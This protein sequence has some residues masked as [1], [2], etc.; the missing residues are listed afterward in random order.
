MLTQG[1]VRDLLVDKYRAL[2]EHRCDISNDALSLQCVCSLRPERAHGDTAVVCGQRHR[3]SCNHCELNTH[4]SCLFN[5]VF[6]LDKTTPSS[7]LLHAT[8]QTTNNQ[9]ASF[10]F[11]ERSGEGQIKPLHFFLFHL[12]RRNQF[13]KGLFIM[14][15]SLLACLYCNAPFLPLRIQARVCIIW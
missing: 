1:P 12:H 7:R 5:G 9:H 13:Q 6:H 2:R 4:L 3:P 11:T 8:I 10:G 15:K 14:H